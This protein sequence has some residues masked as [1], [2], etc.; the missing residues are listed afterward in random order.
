MHKFIDKLEDLNKN[1]KTS[2]IAGELLAVYKNIDDSLKM[3]EEEKD[4]MMKEMIKEELVS[5]ELQKTNLENTIESI[6]EKEK[7]EESLPSSLVLEIQAGAGG[8]ESTLFAAELAAMYIAYARVNNWQTQVVDS[9]E[10]DAGGY[11]DVSIE[12][13]G[14]G[15]WEAFCR[16][17]GVHRV[18]RVPDTE[19]NGRIHTSTITVAALPIREK[20]RFELDMSEVEFETSRSGGAG[21]QNVNKVE[22]AVRAIHKPTNIWFRCT[23]ERSQLQNKEKAIEMI[24]AKLLQMKEEEEAKNFSSEKRLQVGTGDRSEKIRTYNFPQDRVTDHR[25]RQSWSGIPRIMA[26]DFSKIAKAL[27]EGKVGDEAE[28]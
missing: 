17:T 2:Y 15:A 13:K 6:L 26:G 23:S 14:D 5:L 12:V 11:K 25:I 18:Q 1:Y 7:E 21:G 9:S 16:E 3:I 10:S 28:E 4:D 22:T 20:V 8:S 19:K 24:K 27:K